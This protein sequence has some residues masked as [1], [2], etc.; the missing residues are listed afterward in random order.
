M[1]SALLRGTELKAELKF[2]MPKKLKS[3]HLMKS[4]HINLSEYLYLY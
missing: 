4:N 2:L 3:K 1:I